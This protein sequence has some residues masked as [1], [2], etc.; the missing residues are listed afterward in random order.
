MG[1]GIHSGLFRFKYTTVV[2]DS[3]YYVSLFFGYLVV[4]QLEAS[5]A[6]SNSSEPKKS[7]DL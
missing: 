6:Q 2:W 5:I 7:M 1:V 3:F 4:T